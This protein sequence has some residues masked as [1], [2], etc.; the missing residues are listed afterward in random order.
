MK[1]ATALGTLNADGTGEAIWAIGDMSIGKPATKN[2]ASWS[3]ENGGL[4]LAR[5]ADKKF[6]I[7]LVG[8]VS[9]NATKFDFKLFW[10]KT[11]GGEFKGPSEVSGAGYG[12]ISTTS[13]IVMV[14]ATSGNIGLVT[15]KKLDLGG[16]YRFTVDVS[17]GVDNAVLTVEKIG[18]QPLPPADLKANGITLTQID[19]DN[20]FVNLD[21]TK[22]QVIAFSGADMFTPLWFD[23]NFLSSVTSTSATVNVVSGRYR[24]M[25]N[26]GNKFIRMKPVDAAGNDPVTAANGT[27]A[28]Y[29]MAWGVGVPSLDY[30]F[31]WNPGAAYSMAQ[32]EPSVYVITGT[33]GP[34]K[35]SVLGN[36]F[37]YDYISLK[38][39][40]QN[41]WGGEMAGA[42]INIIGGLLKNGNNLEL[43]GVQL[44]AGATYELKI[45][46]TAGKDN[47][48]IS[49][50]K[51]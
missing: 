18:D 24:L 43:N 11:W 49:F 4:C 46:L 48:T 19:A 6:Q 17:G 15:G 37:R 38:Y 45:D 30:Q 27:G 28:L 50:V 40:M 47:G 1:S 7:T 9:L 12:R 2:G 5:V 8:G 34:E 32:V 20:Y 44:E 21:L 51:K 16:V 31:G 23:N 33:T 22:G 13:V 26:V 14:N 39:F 25:M 41:G 10:Q 29:M 3:P 42:T 36:Y 35:G